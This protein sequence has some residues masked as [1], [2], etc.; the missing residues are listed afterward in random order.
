MMC[1]DSGVVIRMCGDLRIIRARA[2][3]GVSPV[4]TA[5]R[6]SGNDFPA[7]ANRSRKRGER[8]L[9]VALNVVVQRLERR[10]VEDLH[11]VG[12]RLR[13]APSTM[14]WF[15]SQ[16]NAAS[17]LPVPVGARMSVCAPLAI[18]GHPSRCGALG[19]PSVSRNHA[20]TIG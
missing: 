12:E 8:A 13:A 14:S 17:V 18:A 7:A 9:E 20:R 16:R 5:T 3:A 10:D 2:D 1:S 6:I 11:R 4:R 15:S 19:A